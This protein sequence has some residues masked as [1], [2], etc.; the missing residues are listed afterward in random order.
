MEK[1]SISITDYGKRYGRKRAQSE[2]TK[3]IETKVTKG[4]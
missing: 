4:R 1:R 3:P 2:A